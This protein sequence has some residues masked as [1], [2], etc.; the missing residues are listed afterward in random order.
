[1]TVRI[2]RRLYYSDERGKN[3]VNEIDNTRV[4]FI[5]FIYL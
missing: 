2:A 4:L 5:Y 1:M 3:T